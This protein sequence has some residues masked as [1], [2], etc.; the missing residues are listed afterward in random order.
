MPKAG[1]KRQSPP[2]GAKNKILLSTQKEGRA[3]A[4]Y[5]GRPM[6]LTASPITIY[7]PVFGTFVQNIANLSSLDVTDEELDLTHSFVTQCLEFYDR[8][9]PQATPPRPV[10]PRS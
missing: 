1:R 4:V 2:A 5:N 3:D 9:D 10:A 8:E 7:H 6:E